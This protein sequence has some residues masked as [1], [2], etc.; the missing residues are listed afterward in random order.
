MAL[1]LAWKPE[2]SLALCFFLQFLQTQHEN[3][4]IQR[5][6]LLSASQRTMLTSL[7]CSVSGVS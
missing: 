3:L 2:G 6:G 4:Q 5:A 7:D 1:G